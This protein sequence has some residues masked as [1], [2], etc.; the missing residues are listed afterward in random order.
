MNVKA[1]VL[2]AIVFSSISATVNVK[3]ASAGF[4]DGLLQ[5]VTNQVGDRVKTGIQNG[6]RNKTQDLGKRAGLDIK[7]DHGKGNADACEELERMDAEK[8]ANNKIDEIANETVAQRK[9]RKAREGKII[10][11]NVDKAINTSVYSKEERAF[12]NT[13]RC[14]GNGKIVKFSS[15]TVLAKVVLA[16]N[17]ETEYCGN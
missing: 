15:D 11:K 6:I 13:Y 1:I 16:N 5:S 12:V 3:P 4:L 9:A 8:S 10:G 7:C 17:A 14:L 2:S